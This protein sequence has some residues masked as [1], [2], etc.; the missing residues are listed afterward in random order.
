MLIGKICKLVKGMFAE[1]LHCV[2][3]Y[4]KQNKCFNTKDCFAECRG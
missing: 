1:N 3:M 2:S 4:D